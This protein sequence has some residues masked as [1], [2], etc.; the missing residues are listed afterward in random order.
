[1][2]PK[3]PIRRGM[4]IL[5]VLGTLAIT[6]AVCYA[7][8]RGQGTTSQLARNN[9]RSLQA[10][11]AA[12]SGLAAALRKMSESTWGGVAA[13][14]NSNVTPDSWYE[15]TF[16]TGDTA[17]TVADPKF[18]EFPYR[19]TIDSYGYA[20]DPSDPSVRAIH[21]S[22]CIVQLVRK[23]IAAEP[24]S[25]SRLMTSTVYQ[26]ANRSI[27]LQEPVRINGR[28]TILGRI[29][30]S[31]EYPLTTASRDLYLSDLNA[32]RLEGRGDHRPVESPLYVAL[33]RQDAATLTL[34]TTK[35]GLVTVDTLDS[36]LNPL[37]HPGAVASYQLYPGGKSYAPPVLQT[38][39]GITLSNLTL[40][41]DPVTN[42]LGVFRSTGSLV[43]QNNVQI[44]GTLITDNTSSDVQVFGTNVLI[45]PSSLPKLH[46]SATTYQLPAA[47]VRDDLEINPL[48]SMQLRGFTV[49]WDE[50]DLKR[51]S[52]NTQFTMVGNLATASLLLKGRDTWTMTATDWDNDYDDFT[53]DGGLLGAVLDALLD[54]IRAVLGLGSNDPVFFPEYMQHVRGF[55]VQPTLTFQPDLS[56]VQ[57]HWQNW[58][59]PVF[60]QAASDEGLVWDVIRWEDNP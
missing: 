53:D 49:V 45:Q 23:A 34:L 57:P 26:W 30:L 55:T 20:S 51:G 37:T 2:K 14:F 28:T 6:L 29:F 40:G 41:P 15:V 58:T 59:Q 39:Y 50:F 22:R 24:A 1:M 56:G 4:A 27:Y 8:L 19:V 60:Q 32:M 17:L 12:R 9:S 13:P 3:Q 10:R 47:L 5:L 48:S 54:D 21:H 36:T 35:L 42:P 38:L 52:P 33:A 11:E 43:L 18:G 7:T 44:T 25:M 16:T 46:G 31:T